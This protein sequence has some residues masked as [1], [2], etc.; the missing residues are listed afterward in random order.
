MFAYTVAACDSDADGVAVAA[1][2][3]DLAS[4][5]VVS[6][7]DR[8]VMAELSHEAVNGGAGH[9]VTTACPGQ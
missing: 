9:H 7:T 1:N 2:A 8:M 4:G 5:I 3:F 6:A